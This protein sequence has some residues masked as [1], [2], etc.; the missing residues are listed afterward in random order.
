MFVRKNM[1]HFRAKGLAIC[2]IVILLKKTTEEASFNTEE[3]PNMFVK[4]NGPLDLVE[5]SNFRIKQ[6]INELLSNAKTIG[7]IAT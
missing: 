3:V 5:S 4:L 6:E 1:W 7:K 2:Q